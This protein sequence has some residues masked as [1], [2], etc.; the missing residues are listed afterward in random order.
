[1]IP[2]LK[3]NMPKLKFNE[4]RAQ[5]L[6]GKGGEFLPQLG[7]AYDRGADNGYELAKDELGEWRPTSSMHPDDYFSIDPLTNWMHLPFGMGVA[8]TKL[9][10]DLVFIWDER[11]EGKAT[12]Y[13]KVN[14]PEPP[15]T[16][17]AGGC[18]VVTK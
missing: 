1:M 3:Y 16:R 5:W 8:R 4:R 6:Q 7:R 18:P 15:I 10:N 14:I 17:E 9:T 12:H 2:N 13:Y 11:G